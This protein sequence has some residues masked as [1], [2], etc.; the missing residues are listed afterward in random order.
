MD[1]AQHQSVA[2]FAQYEGVHLVLMVQL[3]EKFPAERPW[4][5]V[6]QLSVGLLGS[7]ASE[8]RD[9]GWSPGWT[10]GEMAER[11]MRYVRN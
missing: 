11:T 2:F 10:A 8:M 3:P 4:V 7:R 9:M 1:T 6:Q 5:S